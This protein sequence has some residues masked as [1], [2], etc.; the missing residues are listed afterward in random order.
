MERGTFSQLSEVC[1]AQYTAV[2]GYDSSVWVSVY[3][4][5]CMSHI[6]NI[7]SGIIDLTLF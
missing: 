5:N 4:T 2:F 6:L 3:Y 7:S 1:Y